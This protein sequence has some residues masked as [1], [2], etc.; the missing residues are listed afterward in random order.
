MYA[1]IFASAAMAT[2]PSTYI[3]K[4][5]PS[6]T[7]I[8]VLP[9]FKNALEISDDVSFKKIRVGAVTLYSSSNKLSA[10]SS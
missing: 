7:A 2:S 6:S 1:A 10:S 3:A 5:A 4:Y 8:F 9:M